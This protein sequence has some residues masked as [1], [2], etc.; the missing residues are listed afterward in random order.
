MNRKTITGIFLLSLVLRLGLLYFFDG[1]KQVEQMDAK[2][3]E[4]IAQN[5]IGGRGFINISDSPTMSRPPVYPVFLAGVYYVFGSRESV[6]KVFQCVLDSVTVLLAAYIALL[7]LNPAAA[8]LTGFI[9]ALY[10]PLIIYSNIKLGET[11]FTFFLVLSCLLLIKSFKSGEAKLFSWAG[12]AHGLATLTRSTT[13][14]F[15]FFLLPL[16]FLNAY[17]KFAL[18]GLII[19]FAAGFAV[20]SV[21]TIRNYAVFGELLPVNT[22]GGYLLWFAIQEDAWQGDKLVELS[23]YREFEDIKGMSWVKWDK[24]LTKRV[25]KYAL[26]HPLD[27]SRKTAVNFAKLWYLPVGK[28]IL[29][30]K[31]RLAA[32]IYQ[33]V[34]I[35]FLLTAAAG[36][37]FALAHKKDVLIPLLYLIYLSVMHSVVVP[38]PRYRLPFEPLV[39]MFAAYG[40]LSFYR[41]FKNKPAVK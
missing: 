33:A 27:Y 1:T 37:Y 4:A 12:I 40:L 26:A 2:D 23:P 28:V 21:W 22:G 15:P 34:F 31:F 16:F 24:L 17:K 39:L 6:V 19:F 41:N 11:V 3:Y 5:L 32:D 8:L 20:I 25:V 14:F 10:P 30:G 13:L 29:A 7:C 36:L 18:K 38:V 9:A 35:I